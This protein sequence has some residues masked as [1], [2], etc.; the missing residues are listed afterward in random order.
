MHNTLYIKVKLE[1]KINM[2]SNNKLPT[3]CATYLVQIFTQL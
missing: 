3:L 1:Q 2:I